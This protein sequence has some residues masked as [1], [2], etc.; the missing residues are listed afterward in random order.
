M[1]IRNLDKYDLFP[2]SVVKWVHVDKING[3]A[4]VVI[5]FGNL[6]ITLVRNEIPEVKRDFLLL[7]YLC[8]KA[9][10]T[11]RRILALTSELYL[12]IG[13]FLIINQ[14][15][16][17]KLH[18]SQTL[19]YYL[20]VPLQSDHQC[21]FTYQINLNFFMIFKTLSIQ[22]ERKEKW[23]VFSFEI[24]PCDLDIHRFLKWNLSW[25]ESFCSWKYRAVPSF[26]TQNW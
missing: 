8:M 25:S 7:M 23:S 15:L 19:L 2:E 14:Y 9:S 26:N 4:I 3:G 6:E 10:L 20:T 24:R 18:Q 13:L 12:S 21:S 16:S 5:D 11:S 22:L 17:Q 1:F